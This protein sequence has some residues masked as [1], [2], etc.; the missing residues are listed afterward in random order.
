MLKFK[1]LIYENARKSVPSLIEIYGID[2]KNA[3][4]RIKTII[5]LDDK[6]IDL[7]RLNAVIETSEPEDVVQDD[8]NPF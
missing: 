4:E 3:K 2:I 7:L 8:Q 1:F 6:Q 5:G